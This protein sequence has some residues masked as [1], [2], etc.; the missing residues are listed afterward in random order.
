MGCPTDRDQG[1]QLRVSLLELN[2]LRKIDPVIVCVYGNAS[3]VRTYISKGVN[4]VAQ[5][6]SRNIVDVIFLRVDTPRGEV[7]HEPLGRCWKSTGAHGCSS[8]LRGLREG[9]STMGRTFSARSHYHAAGLGRPVCDLAHAGIFLRW[10]PR[11]RWVGKRSHGRASEAPANERGGNRYA[12]FTA[13]ALHLDSTTL[14]HSRH[15]GR[16]A[17]VRSLSRP[18]PERAGM[19]RMRRFLPFVGP[20]SSAKVRPLNQ[21]SCPH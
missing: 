5:P 8:R 19:G 4:D 1:L 20:R 7:T 6:I 17:G 16:T 9:P 11:S 14:T 2:Q 12:W 18:P 21:H 13:T 3:A 15:L 10:R